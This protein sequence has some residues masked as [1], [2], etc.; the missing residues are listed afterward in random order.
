LAERKYGEVS[1]FS[2]VQNSIV[3]AQKLILKVLTV[4]VSS[5]TPVAVDMRFEVGGNLSRSKVGPGRSR[6]YALTTT[7]DRDRG[8]NGRN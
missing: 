3:H 4:F 1:A 7:S 6:W 2:K 5:L 8:W